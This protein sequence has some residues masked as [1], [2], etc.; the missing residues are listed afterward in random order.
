MHAGLYVQDAFDRLVPG[1]GM[2]ALFGVYAALCALSLVFVARCVPETKG[3]SLEQIEAELSASP[4]STAKGAK[5][6]LL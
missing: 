1:K 5:G 2:A 4:N 3:K 6:E